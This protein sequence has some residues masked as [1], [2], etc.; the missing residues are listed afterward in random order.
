M[1]QNHNAHRRR[2]LPVLGYG[3]YGVVEKG[4]DPEYDISSRTSFLLLVSMIALEGESN[5]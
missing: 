2:G 5:Q 1:S 3:S 4:T